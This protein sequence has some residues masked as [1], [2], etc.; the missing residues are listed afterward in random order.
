[1]K[2]TTFRGFGVMDDRLCGTSRVL[3]TSRS[4]SFAEAA[5]RP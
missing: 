1:M 4:V 3:G 5:T 2:A